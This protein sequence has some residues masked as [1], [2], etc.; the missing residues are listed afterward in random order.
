MG[1]CLCS[2]IKK[3]VP[4]T[5]KKKKKRETSNRISFKEQETEIIDGATLYT[6]N[7]DYK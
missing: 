1:Q 4:R 6:T 7:L 3:I 2:K 5:K